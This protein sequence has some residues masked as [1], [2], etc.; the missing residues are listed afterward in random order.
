MTFQLIQT[1]FSSLGCYN[2]MDIEQIHLLTHFRRK[3]EE[4]HARRTCKTLHRQKSELKIQLLCHG[5]LFVLTIYHLLYACY[6]AT[7]HYTSSLCVYS[8]Q[9]QM[10]TYL[11]SII[12]QTVVGPLH[13][14]HHNT[15]I[16]QIHT[17]SISLS[18]S[19][20]L[21]ATFHAS[22]LIQPNLTKHFCFLFLSSL[23][24][25][26]IFPP[27]TG[28]ANYC[29]T[30]S[31]QKKNKTEIKLGLQGP[32]LILMLNDTDCAEFSIFSPCL[33]GFPPGS[34]FCQ[35]KKYQQQ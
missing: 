7:A 18:L 24:C 15:Y 11:S 25:P 28:N 30:N 17:L 34:L 26:L 5:R 9:G 19:L 10:R 29:R 16:L 22:S 35:I 23:S 8:F 13:T 2:G 3:W 33:H 14:S 32:D 27:N 21:T 1:I 6:V 31:I 20:R 4:R 12:Q